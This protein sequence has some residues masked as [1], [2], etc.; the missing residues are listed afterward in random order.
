M[1]EAGERREAAERK[2]SLLATSAA[3]PSTERRS[4]EAASLHGAWALTSLLILGGGYPQCPAPPTRSQE[5]RLGPWNFSSISLKSSGIP[6][7]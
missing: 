1:G 3:G 2:G 6:H 7:S 4:K 5:N